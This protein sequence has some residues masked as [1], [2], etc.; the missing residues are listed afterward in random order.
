MKHR[1]F[2]GGVKGVEQF[3]SIMFCSVV[4][5]HFT[6][7]WALVPPCANLLPGIPKRTPAFNNSSVGFVF[8]FFKKTRRKSSLQFRKL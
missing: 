2:K 5:K 1:L 6:S 3:V 7:C 8:F 4:V